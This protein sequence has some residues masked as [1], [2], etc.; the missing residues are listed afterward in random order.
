MR[1]FTTALVVE[2]SLPDPVSALRLALTRS[3]PK[4]SSKG[5]GGSF[6]TKTLRDS[7]DKP[8]TPHVAKGLIW[9]VASSDKQCAR[10]S[11][12]AKCSKAVM[13]CV[14]PTP[15]VHANRL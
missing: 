6:A 13:P 10:T 1:P 8:S 4:I 14:L 15:K 7:T 11:N 3:S 9:P 2:R 5:H 12:T